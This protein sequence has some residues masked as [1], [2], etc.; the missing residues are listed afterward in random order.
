M[1][2]DLVIERRDDFFDTSG[3]GKPIPGEAGRDYPTFSSIPRSSFSCK[4][5]QWPGY[6]ADVE[7]RCQVNELII[8]LAY[9]CLLEMSFYALKKAFHSIKFHLI[10]FSISEDFNLFL[11]LTILTCNKRYFLFE[12]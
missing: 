3:D 9:V 11:R 8:S 4:D 10:I 7:S 1:N 2:F 12:L 5:Q 6:Y